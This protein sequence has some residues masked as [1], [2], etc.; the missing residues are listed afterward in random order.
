MTIHILTEEV[1]LES[2]VRV[3]APAGERP[4]KVVQLAIEQVQS[5]REKVNMMDPL[6]SIHVSKPKHGEGRD[7]WVRITYRIRTSDIVE[8]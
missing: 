6:T 3:L 5:V 7:W 4:G 8:V 2:Q 1:T